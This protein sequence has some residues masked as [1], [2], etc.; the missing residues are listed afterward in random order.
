MNVTLPCSELQ[1]V[2][3]F[4]PCFQNTVIRKFNQWQLSA[5]TLHACLLS[6]F[7][8]VWLFLTLWTV[9]HH[10]PLFMGF[11]RQEYL[12][13]LPF[14]P[15]GDLPYPGIELCLL[16]FLH[17][18]MAFFFFFNHKQHLGSPWD[19]K[20]HPNKTR[21]TGWGQNYCFHN[22]WSCSAAATAKSLQSCPTLSDPM[23]CSLPGSSIHGIFQAGVLEW[24]WPEDDVIHLNFCIW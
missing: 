14:P 6:C 19:H 7:S 18:Q 22:D 1:N 10:A 23:D 8:C 2:L 5:S 20:I 13:G 3:W 16:H 11:F 17:W 21:W 4:V 15:P 12:S 9:A 24:A